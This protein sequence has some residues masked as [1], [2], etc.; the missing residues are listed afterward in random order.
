M[1]AVYFKNVG[2]T[3]TLIQLLQDRA[4]IQRQSSEEMKEKFCHY[5]LEL[6]EVLIG[7]PSGGTNDKQIELILTQLRSR[8]IAE[9]QVETY[10]RQER[11][12]LKERELREAEAR[13]NQQRLL[14]ESELSIR[15]QENAG[16]AEY[17]RAVQQAAQIRALSEAEADK[18]KM[19]GEAEAERIAR[20]G[21][22]DAIATDEKV[23][24]YGGPRF[25]VTQAVLSR[26]S[27][28]IEKS[29]VDVVPRVIVGGTNGSGNGSSGGVLETLLSLLLTEKVGESSLL[30]DDDRPKNPEIEA[31]RQST[32]DKVNQTAPLEQRTPGRSL[33]RLAPQTES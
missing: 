33:E 5:N 6:E 10:A 1:V 32:R 16:K 2:Q 13:A 31:L 17:Q 9:E 14:T 20:I 19:M 18:L 29:G 26:F 15:V 21:V 27:E 7:T 22:A 25:Q 30:A 28:A 24:A 11:A 23:R 4:S 8:Q 3:R 12:A